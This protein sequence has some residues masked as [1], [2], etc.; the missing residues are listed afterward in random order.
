MRTLRTSFHNKKF[1]EKYLDI[2]EK[3]SIFV[4]MKK[5]SQ[6]PNDMAKDGVSPRE[7]LVYAVLHSYDNPEH[8]VFPSLDKL[9]ERSQL[10]V[11]TIRASLKILEDAGYIKIE[12]IGRKNY[13]TFSKYLNFEP[14]SDEF[15]DNKDITPTTKA[16]LVAAQQFMYKDVEGLGKL[17]Y[18]NR[19]MSEHINM[20]ESSIRKCNKELEKKNYL[21]VIKNASLGDTKI[22]NLNDLGQAIIWALQNHEER[23][24]QNTEKVADLEKRM[25]VLEKQLKSK[26]EL[27]AK[28]LKS[29]SQ[30]DELIL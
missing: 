27:L 7:Q 10:S 17:S 5:H 30:Q 6:V 12:K 24:T 28:L 3:V 19:V 4:Y 1:S 18:S 15:L 16:Y 29:K 21:T 13:Y 14:F 26:D 25:E 9:A 22:F 8:K 23:I 2:S 11:P 20:P